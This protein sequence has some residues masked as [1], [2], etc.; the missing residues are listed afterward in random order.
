MQGYNAGFARIYNQRWAWFA[1]RL[2][3]KI[4]A[5]YAARATCDPTLP[6]LDLAC[7]TGQMAR[8]FAAAGYRTLGVD[9]SAAMLR[10]ARQNC[11]DYTTNGTLQFVQA[12]MSGLPLAG[13]F[14]LV[15]STYD[16]VN[17][18]PDGA[19]LARL[20]TAVADQLAP[21]GMFVFDM[22][23]R[24]GL[25]GWGTVNVQELPDLFL[26]MRGVFAADDNRATMQITGF[27]RDNSGGG[28][29][30]VDETAYNTIFPMATVAQLLRDA[31][32]SRMY[33]AAL[34][35]LTTA[36]AD[37]EAISRVCWVVQR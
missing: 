11:A 29:Q 2:A 13:K 6:I 3:P 5:L 19:A 26:V 8:H 1:E 25:V 27:V 31:G 7:G 37:P 32:F 35:D 9:L 4:A 23:T 22:N 33:A 16:A 17:H 28:W 18:L 15:V 10:H 12:D 34:D 36:V 14:G 21:G 24:A 30:R 20:F